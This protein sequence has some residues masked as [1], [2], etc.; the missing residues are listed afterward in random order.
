MKNY[1]KKLLIAATFSLLIILMV[2]III[3]PNFIQNGFRTF[4]DIG[5]YNDTKYV[6]GY[7]NLSGVY[8]KSELDKDFIKISDFI[9]KGKMYFHFI[10]ETAYFTS[11]G[12]AIVK[13]NLVNYKEE[14]YRNENMAPSIL[15]VNSNYLIVEDNISEFSL[16]ILSMENYT[17]INS[18]ELIPRNY[19]LTPNSFKFTDYKTKEEYEYYF[20]DNKLV[21]SN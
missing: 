1:N 11:K 10:D 21:K 17:I 18:F 3:F 12:Y 20:D 13:I 7:G 5:E 16:K 4:I 8:K 19:E 2:F 14:V 6:Y 15:C 9:P